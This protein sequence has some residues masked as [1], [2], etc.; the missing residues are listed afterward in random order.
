[1]AGLWF[2]PVSSSKEA[3]LTAYASLSSLYG[4][5][6]WEKLNTR[7]KI[8]KLSRF[9]LTPSVVIG[10]D[11]IGSCKFSY[12]A[13]TATTPRLIESNFTFLTMADLNSRET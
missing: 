4:E 12:H 10:T 2:S 13:I 9:E 7:R 3:G 8:R 11:C 1:V 5:A 6:G